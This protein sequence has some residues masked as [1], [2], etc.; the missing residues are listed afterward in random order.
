[1]TLIQSLPIYSWLVNNTER[2]KK[3]LSGRYFFDPDVTREDF[4]QWL[5]AKMDSKVDDLL[6]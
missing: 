4:K 3:Q 6:V 5:F 2:I 1:M